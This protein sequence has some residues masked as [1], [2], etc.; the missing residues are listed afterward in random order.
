MCARP[1]GPT[2]SASY[3]AQKTLKTT[4]KK[5]EDDGHS[6]KAH[7]P[8]D[9]QKGTTAHLWRSVLVDDVVDPVALTVRHVGPKQGLRD[10]NL[11]VSG[12]QKFVQVDVRIEGRLQY[13]LESTPHLKGEAILHR[14]QVNNGIVVA[15]F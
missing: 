7:P 8:V 15:S 6:L 1:C 2:S 9:M 13:V 12:F 5:N 10:V 14:Q 11:E 4:T 3:Q